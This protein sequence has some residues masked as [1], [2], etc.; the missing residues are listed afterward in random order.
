M[1]NFLLEM[2]ACFNVM[3]LELV[4]SLCTSI[5]SLKMLVPISLNLHTMQCCS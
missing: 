1:M 3:I 5:V 4:L 2:V